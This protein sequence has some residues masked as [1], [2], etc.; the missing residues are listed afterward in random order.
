M[1]ANKLALLLLLTACGDGEGWE[2]QP[3]KSALPAVFREIATDKVSKVCGN[4][5]HMT[6][7]GCVW[8]DYSTGLCYVYTGPNPP[9]WL[10]T[11]ELLHCAGFEHA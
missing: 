5:A 8:R 2:K 9:Y 7:H 11:H 3:S 1:R 10:M 6:T 4:Y